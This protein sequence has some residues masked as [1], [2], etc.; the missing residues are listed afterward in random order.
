MTFTLYFLTFCASLSGSAAPANAPAP[1]ER[2]ESSLELWYPQPADEWVEA[3]PVGN[4]RLGGMVFGGVLNERIQLNEETVWAGSCQTYADKPDGARTIEEARRLFFAGRYAEGEELIQREIMNKHIT[5]RSYQTLGDLRLVMKDPGHTASDYRRSLDLDTATATTQFTMD[6]VTYTR[7]VFASVADDV[8]VVRITA[9]QPGALDLE[10]ALDRPADSVTSVLDGQHL[11]M[12]GQASQNG[13][14]KG[15]RFVALLRALPEGGT[16]GA[17]DGRLKLEKADA[18]TLL[19]SAATDYN[20]MKPDAPLE[21]DLAATCLDILARAAAKPYDELRHAAL[22]EHQRLFRRVV[23]DL[24]ASTAQDLPTNQ[25]LER[26]RHGEAD[27][28]LEAL[29]FQFGRY[30]L[31]S[32]SR[33]GNLPANL[34][35]IWNEHLEAPWDSDYHININLQMNYW[36]AEVTNLGECHGP[37]FDFIEGVV[38]RGRDTARVTYGCGG[39]TAHHTTDAWQSTA[40]HGLVVWG[41]WPMAG[42]WCAQHFFEHFRYTGDRRFLSE[43]AYPILK[44]A[45]LFYLDWLTEDP[46]SG[47]LVSGPGVSPENTFITPEGQRASLSMGCAMDQ[48]IIWDTFTNCLEA[49]RILGIDDDFTKRVA[50][51]LQRLALPEIGA[52]GRLKEWRHSFEEAEPGHRHMSHLFGL[53]PGRQF[54][55]T[56]TP[57]FAAAA[58]ASLDY[59]LAHGGGHT[60]WS[61]AWLINFFARLHDGEAAYENLRLLLSK[62]TL[63]NLFD[64]HPPFQID[65]NFGGTAG[66]AEML[67]QSHTD[68]IVL[69]PALPTAWKDGAVSGLVAR[70]G[71]EIGMKWRDGRLE[72]AAVHSRLGNPGTL[73][74]GPYTA[75]LAGEKGERA[76]FDGTLQPAAVRAR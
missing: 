69:L 18:L 16:L 3:L 76:L 61:R 27:P 9:S 52:D 21:H 34:Q 23:L 31:I 22:A 74:Y 41:M 57:E 46:A 71:F 1:S 70:G 40:P 48:E 26:V 54:T 65:G 2:S 20:R 72:S 29:Y 67:I 30:L 17:A 73:R 60:G 36:P 15:V 59:R 75:A 37:F 42:G 62:S 63:N 5:P 32:S 45:A 43:R 64:N 4:G 55:L 49:A 44:E 51:A 14:Q 25:R 7:E 47:E 50:A 6:G 68:E 66:I 33:P 12:S 35:G 24:G 19:L 8:L 28:G 38:R 53:H 39:F 58:R 10:I 56:G 11:A 13:E